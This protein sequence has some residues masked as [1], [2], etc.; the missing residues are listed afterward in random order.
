[1][2]VD[3]AALNPSTVPSIP[4]RFQS[5][6]YETVPGEGN[7]LEL[8]DATVPGY[9]GTHRDSVGPADYDPNINVKYSTKTISFAKVSGVVIL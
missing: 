2:D 7:K 5:Y 8:Q 3:V 9:S 4:T 6:G 1:M